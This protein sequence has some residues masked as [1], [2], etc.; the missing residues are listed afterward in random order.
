[1][2]RLARPTATELRGAFA[3]LVTGNPQLPKNGADQLESG[4]RGV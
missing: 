3:L 1:M 4:T 2:R